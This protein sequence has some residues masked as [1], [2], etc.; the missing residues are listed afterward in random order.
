M[1]KLT[2]VRKIQI[3]LGLLWLL[4]G[5]LQLQ[6]KMFTAGFAN[7]AIGPA[8]AGQPLI[9]SGPIHFG[10][11]V[12]LTHPTLFNSFFAIIQLLIGVLILNKK[13]AR[14]GLRGSVLWGLVV[15]SFGEAFAGLLGGNG[16]L[17]MGLPG[18]AIIYVLLSVAILPDRQNK[19]K[20]KFKP[21]FWLPLLWAAIWIIGAIYQLLPGQNTPAD[22]S[23]MVSTNVLTTPSWLTS[24]HSSFSN[25]FIH[26]NYWVIVGLVIIEVIVGLC[27][28]IPGRI[29][30]YGVVLGAILSL[31]FWVVGQNLGGY[32]TGFMTD[33]GSGP[34][35]IILGISILSCESMKLKQL[36]SLSWQKLEAFIT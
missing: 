6:P 21:S 32:Y 34:L 19:V 33:P 11:R 18:A 16:S 35:L 27:V 20:E 25:I 14:I 31:I 10:I 7:Q 12:F 24:L 2:A 28:F 15:W 4:D 8:A 30:R 36:S 9:I 29:M 26:G 5:F 17:I 13:T 3:T 1:D 23:A 22:I